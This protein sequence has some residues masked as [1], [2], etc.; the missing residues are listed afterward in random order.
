[1]TAKAKEKE[2]LFLTCACGTEGIRVTYDEYENEYI[3]ILWTHYYNELTLWQRIKEA[4]RVLMNWRN[5]S[6]ETLLTEDDVK[7]LIKYLSG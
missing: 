5:L 2:D 4:W 3:F 6:R 1:M 7:K